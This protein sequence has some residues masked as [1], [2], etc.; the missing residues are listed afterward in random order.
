MGWNP[1]HETGDNMILIWHRVPLIL[2]LEEISEFVVDIF[3]L[4]HCVHP[5]YS[6]CSHRQVRRTKM[7][8]AARINV[9]L[10]AVRFNIDF[11]TCLCGYQG[12][13]L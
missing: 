8:T 9:G 7:L 10:A 11:N 12:K 6:T 4:F 2:H 13:R 3:V 1:S 5:F